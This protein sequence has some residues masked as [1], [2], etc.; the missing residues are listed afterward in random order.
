MVLSLLSYYTLCVETG[1]GKA[2]LSEFD[3]FSDP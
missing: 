2:G 1:L 3:L